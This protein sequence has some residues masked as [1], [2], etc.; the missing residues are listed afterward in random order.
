MLYEHAYTTNLPTILLPQ[1]PS[2]PKVI[3][4]SHG[5]MELFLAFHSGIGTTLESNHPPLVHWYLSPFT[6]ATSKLFVHDH[7]TQPSKRV[8]RAQHAS[9]RPPKAVCVLRSSRRQNINT[10]VFFKR[11]GE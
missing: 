9:E 11:L 2:V 3:R 8:H 6:V 5:S 4:R 1:V 7:P 10:S